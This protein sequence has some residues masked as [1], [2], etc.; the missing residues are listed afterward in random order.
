MS[1]QG[2]SSH[3]SKSH[4]ST[5]KSKRMSAWYSLPYQELVYGMQRTVLFTQTAYLQDSREGE[6][7]KVI[8]HQ[9]A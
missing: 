7:G 6:E 3:F 9:I 2:I 8:N 1:R 4:S 5:A